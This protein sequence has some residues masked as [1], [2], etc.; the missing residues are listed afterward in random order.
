LWWNPIT[1]TCK[2]GL[3]R[4]GKFSVTSSPEGSI[5]YDSLRSSLSVW[6]LRAYS[7]F[8]KENNC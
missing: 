2:T 6:T 8:R 7:V 4:S 5:S 1:K 3:L